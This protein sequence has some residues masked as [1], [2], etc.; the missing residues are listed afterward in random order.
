MENN[1]TKIRI[2][3]KSHKRRKNGTRL[4]LLPFVFAVATFA[5]FSG[6]SG[7]SSQVSGLIF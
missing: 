4:A 6:H 2:A 5:P 7:L 1:K 3:A